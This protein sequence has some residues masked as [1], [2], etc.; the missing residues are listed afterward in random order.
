MSQQQVDNAT[1]TFHSSQAKLND[2]KQAVAGAEAQ[3][4]A[5][6]A[7]VVAAQ[8]QE[9]QAEANVAAAELEL[10]YCTIVA[11]VTGHIAHR[12]VDVGNYVSPG[13]AMFAVV[14]DNVWVTANF[15]EKQ[16]S[17]LKPRQPVNIS[18]DA[19]PAVT[20]HGRVDSFQ[21]GTGAAFSVLPAENATGNWV[22]VVQRL[23][24]KIVFDDARVQQH[25]LAPGMSA[26]PSVKTD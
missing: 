15:K 13:Q 22:K 26:E 19:V 8:A 5:G 21:P 24:V 11:P 17:R 4:Q 18:V 16:L 1:A 20:F 3:L 7:Q 10:S 9:Q 6:Q 23:P 25:F 2:A 14:Q 12:N